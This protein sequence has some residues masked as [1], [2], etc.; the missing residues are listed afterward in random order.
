MKQTSSI[1]SCLSQNLMPTVCLQIIY[2]KKAVPHQSSNV[3]LI[4]SA[5]HKVR[6]ITSHLLSS[7]ACHQNP[8]APQYL[9]S[10]VLFP[11]TKGS[12]GHLLHVSWQC[13]TWLWGY[14]PSSISP[15]S[16]HGPLLPE[17]NPP[18]QRADSLRRC[19]GERR[20]RTAGRWKEEDG[21]RL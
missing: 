13:S 21:E 18:N 14:Q 11:K 5:A 1:V 12:G 3:M 6:S 10:G 17:G 2:R 8:S 15:W 4:I 16:E 19:Y 7:S 20:G 9:W